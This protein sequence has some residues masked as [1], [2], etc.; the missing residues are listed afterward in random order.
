MS[1]SKPDIPDAPTFFNDKRF[2]AG[3]NDLRRLGGRLTSFDF[4]GDL[5]PLQQTIDLDPEVTRLALE[6]AENSLAPSFAQQR[7]DTVNELAR[8]GALESS[9]TADALSRIDETLGQQRQSIVTGAALEDRSRALQNRIALFGEGLN[10]TQTATQLA[11]ANQAQRNNFN[12]Q[13]FENQVAAAV[14]VED[15][16]GGIAG[17]LTGALGAGLIATGVGAGPGLALLAGGA[18]AAAGGFGPAGTGGSILN[19]ATS[20]AALGGP[21]GLGLGG[22]ASRVRPGS[23]AGA[24]SRLSTRG[25]LPKSAQ[26]FNSDIFS[27]FGGGLI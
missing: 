18:G 15:S 8:L 22:L 17:A 11:E 25:L 20:L 5:A 6:F 21:S 27:S 26:A 9:T 10:T 7:Q 13:N 2:Q 23:T 3:I 16:S 19:S 1:K 4:S 12:L 24:G 14:G